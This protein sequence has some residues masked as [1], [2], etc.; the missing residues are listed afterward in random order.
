MA[1]KRKRFTPIHPGEIL[2][3]EFLRPL[4]VTQYRLARDISVP[5]PA[6][7]RSF[8]ASVVSLPPTSGG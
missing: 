5:P 8:L 6:C 3:E 4:S 2:L 1:R 7:G